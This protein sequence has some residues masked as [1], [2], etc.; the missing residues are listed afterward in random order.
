M[1]TVLLKNKSDFLATFIKLHQ[2]RKINLVVLY[3]T[4]IVLLGTWNSVLS[5]YLLQL[6]MILMQFNISSLLLY[7]GEYYKHISVIFTKKWQ[8]SAYQ[9]HSYLIWKRMT[10]QL[11]Y[12]GN[13]YAI[14]N[15]KFEYNTLL[16]ISWNV[17]FS[18]LL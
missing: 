9:G 12:A 3:T 13:S 18:A 8:S 7:F 5:T 6:T 11:I 10:T 14:N 1:K 16:H 17:N 2:S 4:V 15:I